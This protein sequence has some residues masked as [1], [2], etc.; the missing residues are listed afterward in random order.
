MHKCICMCC[1]RL[2]GFGLAFVIVNNKGGGL[3]WDGLFHPALIKIQ[4]LEFMY[5]K[6]W[7]ARKLI[8][9]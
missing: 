6:Y 9:I 4:L 1:W 5:D 2:R 8:V 3:V 7:T